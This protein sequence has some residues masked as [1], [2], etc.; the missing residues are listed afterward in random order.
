MQEGYERTVLVEEHDIAAGKV[1]G[2][3]SAQAG[4]CCSWLAQC[5]SI[6]VPSTLL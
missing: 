4:N 5:L 3:S 2:V 1:D 6:S